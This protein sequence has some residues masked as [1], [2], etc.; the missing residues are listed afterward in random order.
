[1]ANG[2][3]GRRPGAGRPA[4]ADLYRQPIREAEG[5]IRDKLPFLVG[6]LLQLAEGVQMQ[7]ADSKGNPVVYLSPP[8][9]KACEYLI[10][11]VMGTPVQRTESDVRKQA[12]EL[13]EELGLDADELVRTAERIANRR[14]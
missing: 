2:R 10:N 5:L 6:Q 4:R 12:E 7:K 13:A 3:G 8:D 14:A 11:R 1:M 9:R